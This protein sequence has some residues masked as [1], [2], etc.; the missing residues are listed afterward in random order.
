[1]VSSYIK[2]AL[3]E[4]EELTVPG[5]GTFSSRSLGAEVSMS[6]NMITP[7]HAD[8]SFT[9]EENPSAKNLVDYIVEVGGADVTEVQIQVEIFV[10]NIRQQVQTGDVSK[11]KGFGYFKGGLGGRLLFHQLDEENVLPDSY[12][13]PKIT[14]TPIIEDTDAFGSDTESQ[15]EQEDDD[16][17]ADV[18]MVATP[19]DTETR[20]KENK[21]KMYLIAAVPLILVAAIGIYFFFNPEAL[22]VLLGDDDAQEIVVNENP[23][24][25]LVEGS[26]TENTEGDGNGQKAEQNTEQVQS[27]ENSK[28]ETEPNVVEAKPEEKKPVEEVEKPK[29]VVAKKPEPKPT[30]TDIFVRSRTYRFYIIV[31]SLKSE[32][33]AK[34]TQ[35]RL[36]AKGYSSAKIIPYKGNYRISVGDYANKTGAE[37]KQK[38]VEKAFKGAWVWKY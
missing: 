23:N 30:T 11:I 10:T 25:P 15:T 3:V 6:G 2:E 28:S 31:S 29:V 36:E 32:A 8:V 24:K 12:G 7:P 33:G 35:K 37:S 34:K 9:E 16:Y 13:L 14:T 19:S 5:L 21:Q 38:T 17:D 4:V 27:E 22:E 1:M 26:E 20:D 18:P